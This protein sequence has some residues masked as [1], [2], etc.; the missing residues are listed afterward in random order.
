MRESGFQT[1]SGG[2]LA[3]IP[4]GGLAESAIADLCSSVIN[5]FTADSSTSP[6][7]CEINKQTIRWLCELVGYESDSYGDICSGGSQATITALSVARKAKNIDYHRQ[8]KACIYIS[9]HTHHCMAKSI[10]LLFNGGIKLR[11]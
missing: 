7:A 9:E 8:I 2:H 10:N 6:Y 3:Y 5:H 4:G 1:A 11:K